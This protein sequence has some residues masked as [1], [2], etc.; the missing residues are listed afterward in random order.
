MTSRLYNKGYQYLSPHRNINVNSYP[1]P[2]Y[3]HNNERIQ[4]RNYR[5]NVHQNRKRYIEKDRKDSFTLLTGYGL[6]LFSLKF[7]C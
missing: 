6:N 7:R 4:V 5:A 2:K 1:H 3:F